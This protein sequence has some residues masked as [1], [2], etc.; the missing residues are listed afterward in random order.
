MSGAGWGQAG[1]KHFFGRKGIYG[2]FQTMLKSKEV[3]K[4]EVSLKTWLQESLWVPSPAC[5]FVS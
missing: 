5:P 4:R 2:F 1:R 3:E